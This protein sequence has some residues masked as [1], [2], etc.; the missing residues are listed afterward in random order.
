MNQEQ[1]L[2]R[3]EAATPYK[4][5]KAR[6]RG[7]IAKSPEV[8]SAVVFTAAMAFLAWRGWPSW[9]GVFQLDRTLLVEAA[10]LDPTPAG[11]WSLV[12]RMIR[13]TLLLA[14][15]YFL[16]LLVAAVVGNLLQTGPVLS[17]QPIKPDWNRINPTTGLKQLFSVRTLFNG[18]RATLKLAILGSVGYAAL[19]S[20][21]P[22][23]HLLANLPPGGVVRTVLEDLASLGLQ[24]ALALGVIALVDLVYTRREF[25]KKMRM[26]RR[27]L[28]D[29]LKHR[30]GDPK[31]RARLRELRREMLKRAMALRKTR[32]ADVL[33]TNP[34]HLAV[35]LRYVHGEMES[36]QLV[37]KGAGFLA[38]VMREI[39]ARHRIPV[40]Q[41]PPLARKLFH[42]LAID[43]HVPPELYAQVARIL[44]WVLAMREARNG[45]RRSL[46][47]SAAPGGAS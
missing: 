3:N 43:R 40:V 18:V 29:E 15:P 11:L 22:H 20:L 46:R 34:T 36:P 4:L 24:M 47:P 13:E 19:K 38:G 35:A 27:E 42:G 25:A 1:D 9:R 33:I 26:S 6:E 44:V 37:A 10:R 16:T 12:D 31:I 14:A 28:R 41:N 7:Q 8:V 30:E 45:L 2:D 23:F 39:A 21:V 32:D 17:I 5:E